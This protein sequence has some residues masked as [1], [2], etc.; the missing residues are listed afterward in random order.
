MSF[1]VILCACRL[2]KRHVHN[3]PNVQR[4]VRLPL[5][6][7]TV[8]GWVLRV[9]FQSALLQSHHCLPS[10]HQN[11]VSATALPSLSVSVGCNCNLCCCNL[12][13]FYY[14][15]EWV[16]SVL[17]TTKHSSAIVLTLGNKVI[18]YILHCKIIER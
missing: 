1:L 16:M 5:H 6:L 14:W 9:P 18:L 17:G 8:C 4:L 15:C 10:S 12:M 13:M 3:E 11:D 7:Q 2:A